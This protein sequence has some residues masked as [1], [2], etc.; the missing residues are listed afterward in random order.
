MANHSYWH[1]ATLHIETYLYRFFSGFLDV[2]HAGIARTLTIGYCSKE[3]MKNRHSCKSICLMT[4][5]A[6]LLMFLGLPNFG[7]ESMLHPFVTL[8]GLSCVYGLTIGQGFMAVYHGFGP[9]DFIT[10]IFMLPIKYF[11]LKQGYKLYPIHAI[12]L[13]VWLPILQC[14]V[15]KYPVAGLHFLILLQITGE[16]F[17]QGLGVILVMKISRRCQVI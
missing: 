10:P 17:W 6:T 2:A 14:L 1:P 13:G 8:F 7:F 16:L 3:V 5:F 4:S 12:A 15:G 11:M 9:I